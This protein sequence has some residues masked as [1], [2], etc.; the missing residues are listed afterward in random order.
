MRFCFC[1]IFYYS[2]ITVPTLVTLHSFTIMKHL[3]I[4]IYIIFFGGGG[5]GMIHWEM[6]VK[7]T[8]MFYSI[9]FD[10]WINLVY[11]YV[12]LKY[13]ISIYMYNTHEEQL[14]KTQMVYIFKVWWKHLE[15]FL[16]LCK[17][18]TGLYNHIVIN[19]QKDG[20]QKCQTL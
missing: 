14:S 5:G 3:K 15:L 7:T 2:L 13:C 19:G 12:M 11:M 18:N 20:K 16:S 10:I 17:L 6:L 1:M 8:G 4:F 9:N